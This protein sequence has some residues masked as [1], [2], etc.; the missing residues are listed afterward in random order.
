VRGGGVAR[1]SEW[2]C[3]LFFFLCYYISVDYEDI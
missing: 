2:V 1:Q 3:V